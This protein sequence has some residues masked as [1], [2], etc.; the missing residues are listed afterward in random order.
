ERIKSWYIFAFSAAVLCIGFFAVCLF[1]F[2]TESSARRDGSL[3]QYTASADD[4]ELK[5]IT[6]NK[7]GYKTTDHDSQ[8]IM[9]KQQKFSS[10]KFYM[11]YTVEPGEIVLYYKNPGDE[12]FSEQKR[13][14]AQPVDHEENRYIVKMPMK[15]VTEIRLDPSMFAGNQL[16]FGD[17]VFNE[18]KTVTD[19]FAVTYTDVFCLI[20]Y[21]LV[22]SACLKYGQEFLLRKFD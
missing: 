18:E 10:M 9:E 8:M 17:F 13:L 16:T 7:D 11:T 21:T 19:Y 22:I 6:K 5:H 4:F 14:W 15:E 2:V 3:V 12:H 1:N 20:L